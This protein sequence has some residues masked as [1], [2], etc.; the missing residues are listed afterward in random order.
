MAGHNIECLDGTG[1]ASCKLCGKKITRDQ[2]QLRVHA[3]QESFNTHLNCVL[4]PDGLIAIKKEEQDN[5]TK[6][7]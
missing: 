3:W 7:V 4:E 5:E 1:L 6:T 2:K